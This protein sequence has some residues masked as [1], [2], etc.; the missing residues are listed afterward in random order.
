[1]PEKSV[2]YR[3]GPSGRAYLVAVRLCPLGRKKSGGGGMD[4]ASV[5]RE[6][7][8]RRSACFLGGAAGVAG[9]AV[10]L[11]ERALRALGLGIGAMTW[12]SRV[13]VGARY[14]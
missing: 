14:E 4:G 7:M 11:E 8:V 3:M 5:G 9:L 13:E 6:N 1:M 2:A 10:T 12:R